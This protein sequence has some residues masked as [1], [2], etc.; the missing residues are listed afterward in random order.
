M[1][2]I[3][4]TLS[5]YRAIF[6]A[7]YA[8]IF[9]LI[10]MTRM[11]LSAAS[12]PVALWPHGAPGEKATT[13]PEKDMT[14]ATDGLVA[15]KRLIRLGNVTQPD[16]TVYRPAGTKATGSAVVVFPGGGYRILALDLEGTEICHW[17]NSLGI[18]AVLLKY[19]VPEPAGVP[20]Y[21]EPLQDAQRAVS[22][23]RSH[24]ADWKLNP[25]QI[26]VLGFSAGGHLAAVLSAKFG[27][28]AYPPVDAA[29]RVSCQ[30]DFAVLVYPAYLSVRDEGDQL[31]P[32]VAVHPHIG[33][34]FIV[35]AEDDHAFIG[36]TLLYY[37]AL[38]RGGVPAE[39]HVFPSGGHGYGLRLSAARVTNWPTLAETWLRSLKVLGK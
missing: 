9:L 39:I 18:T 5:F 27:S 32:E 4:P 26:G 15:G 14:T 6:A 1:C 2:S 12:Q 29:D 28:R 16:I 22:L 3:R 13:Q 17:L 30:P 38:Q 33:P 10:L 35:Q 20:R 25:D 23:V 37:R 8:G 24:A 19:R 21:A 36:G 11:G 31:A 7:R 34:T